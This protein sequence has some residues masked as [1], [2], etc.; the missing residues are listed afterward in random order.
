MAKL[1]VHAYT[2]DNNNPSLETPKELLKT[3]SDSL[4]GYVAWIDLVDETNETTFERDD[5]FTNWEEE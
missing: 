1:L 5:D 2:K 4:G 3:V